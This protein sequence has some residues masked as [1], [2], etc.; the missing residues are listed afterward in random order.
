VHWCGPTAADYDSVVVGVGV[1]AHGEVHG[2]GIPRTSFV[3]R[4]ADVVRVADLLEEFRLVTVTGPGGVGK[5]RLAGA[6]AEVV[7]GRFADGV[8]LAELAVTSD[9]RLIPDLVAEAL[10][11]QLAPG[12]GLADVLARRQ[13]LVVLDNC[14]HVL[15][16]AATLCESLLGAA[17]DVR[18]LA[19]SREA[20]GVAGESRYRLGPLR[21]PVLGGEASALRNAAPCRGWNRGMVHRSVL[22][23]LAQRGKQPDHMPGAPGGRRRCTHGTGGARSAPGTGPGSSRPVHGE[24]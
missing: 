12:V 14:E 17:D 1:A 13:L 8:W 5:T 22:A 9:P 18:V 10:G 16:A 23:R 3:G 6:V 2:F 11:L 20:L 21:L 15:D 24:P 7:A 19:T 4:D